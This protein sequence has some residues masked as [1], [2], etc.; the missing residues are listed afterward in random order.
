VGMIY[1]D[2]DS[3]SA[4]GTDHP[5]RSLDGFGPPFRRGMPGHASAR[6]VDGR[7][8]DS[9]GDGN[10]S[11]CSSGSSR[12]ESDASPQGPGSCGGP[13]PEIRGRYRSSFL[14]AERQSGWGGC[15]SQSL[16]PNHLVDDSL[17]SLLAR[18]AYWWPNDWGVLETE[19]PW[20]PEAATLQRNCGR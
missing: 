10:R 17:R 2:R 20:N 9:K 1:P 16:T 8:G 15:R 3:R 6:N 11:T 19:A 7:A 5:Y 12:H 18:T 14:A 4:E 13:T